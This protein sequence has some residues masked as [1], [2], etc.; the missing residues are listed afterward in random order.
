M[1]TQIDI[2]TVKYVEGIFFHPKLT[3]IISLGLNL[4]PGTKNTLKINRI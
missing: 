4:C 3:N 2:G 1:S